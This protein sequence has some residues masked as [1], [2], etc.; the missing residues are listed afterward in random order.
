MDSYQRVLDETIRSGFVKVNIWC[1][2]L[3][4]FLC[5]LDFLEVLFDPC[6]FTEDRMISCI[7]AVQSKICFSNQ[8]RN[9]LE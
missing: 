2:T 5:V 7:D 9:L 6:Q 3:A 8:L 4:G 1:N